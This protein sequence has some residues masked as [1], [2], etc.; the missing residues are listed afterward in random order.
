MTHVPKLIMLEIRVF[1]LFEI[2]YGAAPRPGIV[3]GVVAAIG[4]V[5]GIGIVAVIVAV[6]CPFFLFLQ[7]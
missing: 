4:I 1:G 3:V 2:A 7:K 5:A 6:A